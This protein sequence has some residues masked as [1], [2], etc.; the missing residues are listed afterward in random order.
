LHETWGAGA[1]EQVLEGLVDSIAT[2]FLTSVEIWSFF[3]H[4]LE[5]FGFL[6]DE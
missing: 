5:G 2:K 6:S 4:T 1:S 3:S